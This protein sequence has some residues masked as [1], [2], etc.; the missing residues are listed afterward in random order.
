[1]RRALSIAGFAL[2]LAGCP[3]RPGPP[4]NEPPEMTAETTRGERVFM[5]FCQE[6]HPGGGGG[7]GPAVVRSPE[8]PSAA[9]R[10]QVRAGAGIMPSFNE[11]QISDA[12]LSALLEYIDALEETV[13]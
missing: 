6:C 4:V 2:L 5:R 11:D 9:I 13:D 3:Q 1:M 8:L 7:R 12:D 10:L